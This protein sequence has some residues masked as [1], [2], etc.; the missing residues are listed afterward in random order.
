[1]KKMTIALLCLSYS[2]FIH[3]NDLIDKSTVKLTNTISEVYTT[4]TIQDGSTLQ[5]GKNG[6]K[7]VN[8]GV[9][10]VPTFRSKKNVSIY[11]LAEQPDGKILVGGNFESVNGHRAKDIVRLNSDGSV[12]KLF[13]PEA[14]GFN[15]EVY[16]IEI[17]KDGTILVGGYFTEL[18][19][20]VSKGFITLTKNGLI[21][22]E[23]DELNNFQVSIVNDIKV[24]QGNIFLS[25]TF[26]GDDNIQRAILSADYFGNLNTKFNKKTSIIRGEGFKIDTQNNSL[27]MAGDINV[28]NDDTLSNVI[29]MD[30]KGTVDKNFSIPNLDGFI[31]DVKSNKN[32]LLIGGSMLVK[33]NKAGIETSVVK[34]NNKQLTPVDTKA[35]STVFT[36]TTSK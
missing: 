4:L 34:F 8:N 16:D 25:G 33:N 10:N 13:M 12:D 24:V 9:F 27:V 11:A 32:S 36:L 3:A 35:Q 23:Y 1:M 18:N 31:F 22:T 5:G 2:S 28:E 30:L 7:I 26:I 19:N 20:E 6:L 14:N 17:L 21:N 15:G 29:K